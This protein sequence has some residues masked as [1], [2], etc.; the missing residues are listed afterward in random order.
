MRWFRLASDQGFHRA[1]T[2]IGLLYK[3]GWGVQQDYAQALDWFRR[4][5]G[6]DD[7]RAEFNIGLAYA[8]GLGVPIDPGAARN[9]IQKA[10]DAGSEPARRWLAA[11][12]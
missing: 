4:A 5:A 7:P 8:K 3:N 6:H 9:W 11:N 12:R 10:A 1:R 2:N